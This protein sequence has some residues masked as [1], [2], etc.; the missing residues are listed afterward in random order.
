MTD[1]AQVAALIRARTEPMAADAPTAIRALIR[2][3]E[4]ALPAV[5]ALIERCLRVHGS[6]SSNGA[7]GDERF[8]QLVAVFQDVLWV[9]GHG[10]RRL[11][12]G[13]R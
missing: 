5:P 1:S 13:N 7:A 6:R 9:H 10:F 4:A 12:R 8:I 11:H 2:L 3:G